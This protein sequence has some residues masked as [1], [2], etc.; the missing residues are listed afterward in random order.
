LLGLPFDWPALGVAAAL[1]CVVLFYAAFTFKRV[2]RH[3]ADII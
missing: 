2:E 1:T 3:F